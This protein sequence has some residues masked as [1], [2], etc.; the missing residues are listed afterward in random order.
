M[1]P[2]VGYAKLAIDQALIQAD[3]EWLFPQYIKEGHC[4]ATQAFN[5]ANKWP[6]NDFGGLRRIVSDIPSETA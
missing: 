6:K 1:F 5:V 2:L 3:D 4:F